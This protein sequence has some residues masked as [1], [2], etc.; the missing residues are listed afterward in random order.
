MR[1]NACAARATAPRSLNR[2]PFMVTA[3]STKRVSISPSSV[4]EEQDLRIDAGL[5]GHARCYRFMPPVDVLAGALAGYAQ[6]EPLVADRDLV[7][8]VGESGEPFD[9]CACACRNRPKRGTRDQP[10]CTS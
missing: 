1:R 8:P 9:G 5:G 4:V 7:V 3:P 2:S 10:G 6:H